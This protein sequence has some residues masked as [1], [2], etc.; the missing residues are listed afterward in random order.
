MEVIYNKYKLEFLDLN[1]SLDGGFNDFT[2]HEYL[3]TKANI[4]YANSFFKVTDLPSTL[5]KL[6]IWNVYYNTKLI[7]GIL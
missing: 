5:A 1:V 3:E 7:Q 2:A 6:R 4:I